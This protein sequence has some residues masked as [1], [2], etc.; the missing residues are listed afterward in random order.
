MTASEHLN[1]ARKALAEGKLH[2]D[3]MKTSF[4]RV[5]DARKHLAA[6]K[7]GAPEYTEA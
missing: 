3:P 6:I 4:G 5:D 2:K 7:E 1:E